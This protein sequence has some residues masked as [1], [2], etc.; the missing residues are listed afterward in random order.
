MTRDGSYFIIGVIAVVFI[1]MGVLVYDFTIVAQWNHYK[2]TPNIGP[3]N[4]TSHL[5]TE[6]CQKYESQVILKGVSINCGGERRA[7]ERL[8]SYYMRRNAGEL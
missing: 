1:F 2:Y 4:E 6:D 7:Y 3:F 8:T 5:Y